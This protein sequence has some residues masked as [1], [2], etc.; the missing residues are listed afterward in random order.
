MRAGQVSAADAEQTLRA[1]RRPDPRRERRRRPGGPAAAAGGARRRWRRSS[2][3]RRR[4]A[5]QEAR[6]RALA[7]RD[8]RSSRRPSSSPPPT[9][10]GSRGRRRGDRLRE[11][12]EQWRRLQRDGPRS[13]STPRTSSGSGSATPGPTF[14]RKRRH[15]FGALDEQRAAAKEAKERIVAE[16]EALSTSTDWGAT[17]AAYRDLMARWKAAG[18]AAEADDDALW[19]RFRAA[20]DAFF[21]AR[22]GGRGADGRASSARTWRSRRRCSPRPRRCCRSPTSAPPG[23]ALRDIQERWDAAGKVPR[24][25]M[26]ADRGPAAAGRA[27]ASATPS[28]TAGRAATPRPGPVPRTPCAQLEQT[29]AGLEADLDA[30]RR[31][32]ATARRIEDAA[33][34]RCRPAG[35]AG[36]GRERALAD[37]HATDSADRPRTARQRLVARPAE[38]LVAS[39][40]TAGATLPR[41]RHRRR[42]HARVGAVTAAAT[43]RC[44]L[45]RRPATCRPGGR[46]SGD[47]RPDGSPAGRRSATA[48]CAPRR[49]RLAAA[50]RR[51][52]R[53]AGRVA[54]TAGLRAAARRGRVAARPGGP[55][56]AGRAVGSATAAWVH[57]GGDG[58]PAELAVP[59]GVACCPPGRGSRARRVGVRLRRRAGRTRCDV[60]ARCTGAVTAPP[61]TRRRPGS[62]CCRPG[63]RDPALA[64]LPAAHRRPPGRG[65]STSAAPSDRSPRGIAP[66]AGRAG[67]RWAAATGGRGAQ[68]LALAG[69][70]VGVEDAVDPP[71]GRDHVAE[72]RRVGHLERE[73]RDRHAVARRR[74]RSRT[75]C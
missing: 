70:P 51:R 71:D 59:A 32:A 28:R 18:R 15:Y 74:A 5:R 47:V 19:A 56:R 22:A 27:G 44:P 11:L 55:G 34:R 40:S 36:A 17:A 65:R 63:D 35:V 46:P 33:S 42:A 31:H 13:T 68:S 29:I 61:R 41:W 24:G 50:D 45:R 30:G 21:A 9:R 53:R 1:A 58:R 3:P 60:H 39:P 64:A 52:R 20:Q 49:T 66:G 62:R 54:A 12:F 38:R 6:E 26:P 43:T 37:V 48:C 4:Q 72:V 73:L 57:T 69:D 8:R 25:D 67:A 2:G 7:L 14:D 10:S 75:G 16:A 23:P